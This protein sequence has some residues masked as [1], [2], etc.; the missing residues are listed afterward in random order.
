MFLFK[1]TAIP[2]L[3]ATVKALKLKETAAPE[4]IPAMLPVK[5]GAPAE[6]SKEPLIVKFL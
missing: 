2:A 6:A 1:V 5:L 4:I 3:L